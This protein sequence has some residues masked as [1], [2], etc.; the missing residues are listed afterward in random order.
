MKLLLKSYVV[1]LVILSI[2]VG[3]GLAFAASDKPTPPAVQATKTKEPSVIPPPPQF[4]PI[5]IN[6]AKKDEFKK[7]TG[8]TE[9]H[10]DRIIAGRPYLSKYVLVT[11]KIIPEDVFQAIRQHIVAKQPDKKKA[12]KEATSTAKP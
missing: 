10:A 9:A 3:A 5:D 12:P 4:A 8:V 7:L 1:K 6:T 2:A 11:D